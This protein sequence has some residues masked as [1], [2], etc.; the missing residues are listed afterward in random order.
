MFWVGWCDESG[1]WE[2]CEKPFGSYL[3]AQMF[4][5]GLIINGVKRTIIREQE[6]AEES[7]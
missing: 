4:V 5:N 6:L 2:F 3:S 1:R 7:A